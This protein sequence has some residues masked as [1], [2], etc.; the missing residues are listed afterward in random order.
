MRT[1]TV[2]RRHEWP[3]GVWAKFLPT[4]RMGAGTTPGK[5]GLERVRNKRWRATRQQL[6][7]AK[8]RVGREP[9][10]TE[11]IPNKGSDDLHRSLGNSSAGLD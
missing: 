3:R 10:L 8:A 1:F 6:P 5:E 7:D 9:S 4:A 2:E 11:F